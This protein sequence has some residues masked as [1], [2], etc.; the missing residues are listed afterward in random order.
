[1]E[2]DRPAF[3]KLSKRSQGGGANNDSP[4]TAQNGFLIKVHF[5]ALYVRSAPREGHRILSVWPLDSSFFVFLVPAPTVATEGLPI[6]KPRLACLINCDFR[7]SCVPCLVFEKLLDEGVIWAVD[8]VPL[9]VLVG[10]ASVTP[11]PGDVGAM[12][13]LELLDHPFVV[14]YICH[15]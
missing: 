8:L 10:V 13:V 9:H 4:L 7:V 3:R 14:I 1:M 2:F 15:V 5:L 12:Y 6:V 11:H